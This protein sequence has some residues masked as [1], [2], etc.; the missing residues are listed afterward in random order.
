MG[1]KLLKYYKY[2]SVESGLKGKIKLA[3][4]TKVP[5]IKAAITPDTEEK[6]ML[7][8]KSIKEITGKDAP[9]F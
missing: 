8:K 4:M 3:V 1:V 2:I 6:I 5:S 9:D 7:F